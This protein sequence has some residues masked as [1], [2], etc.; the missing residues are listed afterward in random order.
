MLCFGFVDLAEGPGR[1]KEKS[2]AKG[3]K[4]SSERA[5]GLT[6]IR[7][8]EKRVKKRVTAVA[9]DWRVFISSYHAKSEMV[10]LS[11]CSKEKTKGKE[12]D[13]WT[14]FPG[15]PWDQNG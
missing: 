5:N 12:R 4:S 2:E 14:S 6:R 7:K 10:F 1:W 3:K 11:N 13:C 15:C 9:R 8:L